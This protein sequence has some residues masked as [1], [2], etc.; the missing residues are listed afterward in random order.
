MLDDINFTNWLPYKQQYAYWFL[1]PLGAKPFASIVVTKPEIAYIQDMHSEESSNQM[2]QIDANMQLNT[3]SFTHHS[4]YSLRRVTQFVQITR[5]W[6]Y[7]L[8]I[9]II[10][11]LLVR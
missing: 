3:R 8:D 1:A 6:H 10:S 7:H 2:C 4:R 11:A 9:I 5:D